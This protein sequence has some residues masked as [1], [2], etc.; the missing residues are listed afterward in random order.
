M[1]AA[2]PV[3][4]SGP[5]RSSRTR[6]PKRAR[7]VGANVLEVVASL[8]RVLVAGTFML[9][10]LVQ[11]FRIPSGSMI[12]TLQ[13]GD[14]VLVSKTD[15]G[16]RARQ[17]VWAQ[18]EQILLPRAE[19]R[20]GDL[21]VFHYPP[22]GSRELVKR[23]VALPGEHVRMHGGR[24]FVDGKSLAEAYT[25]Y[26]PSQPEVFRDEFPNLHEA[27]PNTDPRWWLALR[28]R[29]SPEGDLLVPPDEY[30]VLGDNRN[31][32]EDSRYWG[33]VPRALF[34][35]RPLLVYFAVPD[36]ADAPEGGPWARLQWLLAWVR[37]R[38]GVPR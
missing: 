23:V 12:P 6:V 19:V 21:A 37:A 3:S 24:M 17:G 30:F 36:G 33:F 10:F 29:V 7:H 35:G 34:V 28:Q 27:D 2:A 20:R 14:F 8:M 31:N 25:L 16:P 22:D 5:L 9:T 26:T 4:V 1:N 38:V 15:Y 18:L 32:S 11:P 13:I